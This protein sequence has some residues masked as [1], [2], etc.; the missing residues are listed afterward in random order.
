[1]PRPRATLLEGEA[2]V[3]QGLNIGLLKKVGDFY[4]LGAIANFR[5]NVLTPDCS[6]V[7]V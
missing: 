2:G 6:S 1:M 3:S 4:T 5:L 7:T